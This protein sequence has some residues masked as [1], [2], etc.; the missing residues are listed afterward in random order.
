MTLPSSMAH[1]NKFP[2]LRK[3][4]SF[5]AC[6]PSFSSSSVSNGPSY[7]I[8]R[9]LQSR[10]STPRLRPEKQPDKMIKHTMSIHLHHSTAYMFA[11]RSS[12]AGSSVSSVDPSSLATDIFIMEI[13]ASRLRTW[14]QKLYL[15]LLL[16]ISLLRPM[17]SF[18]TDFTLGRC[19]NIFYFY[20]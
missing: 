7:I 8:Y 19:S 6:F 2:R 5:L 20:L 18:S 17:R 10:P 16:L 4:S 15:F 13:R 9:S 1:S 3:G 14:V 11:M 12:S